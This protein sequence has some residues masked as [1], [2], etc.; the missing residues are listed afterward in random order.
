MLLP[1]FDGVFLVVDGRRGRAKRGGRGGSLGGRR[2]GKEGIFLD[3][4]DDALTWTWIVISISLLVIGAL[5]V[6]CL[7]E[8]CRRDREE[9]SS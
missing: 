3:W 2:G 7:Y 8:C 6:G 1:K 4:G 9:D 5:L